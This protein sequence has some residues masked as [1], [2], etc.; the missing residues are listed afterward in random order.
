MSN[1]IQGLEYKALFV[2]FVLRF[3]SLYLF[4]TSYIVQHWLAGQKNRYLK[5]L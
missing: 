1:W 3:Y 4:F 5:I 2:M